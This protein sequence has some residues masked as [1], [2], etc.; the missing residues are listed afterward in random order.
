[1]KAPKGSEMGCIELGLL[2]QRKTVA[3]V[4]A[5]GDRSPVNRVRCE[6]ILNEIG[7][8]KM[9]CDDVILVVNDHNVHHIITKSSA[10]TCTDVELRIHNGKNDRN[11][12]KIT[13]SLPTNSKMTEVHDTINSIMHRET[14]IN[15]V[16]SKLIVSGKVA[17]NF[18]CLL[19][20]YLL[21]HYYWN[22]KYNRGHKKF[23]IDVFL[24]VESLQQPLDSISRIPDKETCKKLPQRY[25]QNRRTNSFK[26]LTKNYT[27][28]KFCIEYVPPAVLPTSTAR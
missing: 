26:G 9:N 16:N 4:V 21:Y 27:K 28:L 12:T 8:D 2:S 10:H 25:Y 13:L 11:L 7:M 18:H 22:K 15:R 14:K 6:E 20:D 1:M 5:G 19:G 23:V 3:L 17:N 24:V